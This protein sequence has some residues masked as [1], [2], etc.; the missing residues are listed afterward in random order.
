MARIADGELVV[1]LHSEPFGPVPE[2]TARV[3]HAAFP[4]GNTY[5]RLHDEL[6]SI[7]EDGA[8]KKLFPVR[9]QP[10]EAPRR[11]AVVTVLQFAEGLLIVKQPMQCEDGSIES[12]CSAWS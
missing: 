4:T 11:L 9:G 7:Y 8:F 3:A 10:A 1:S 6:G 12:I 5:L 2:Q